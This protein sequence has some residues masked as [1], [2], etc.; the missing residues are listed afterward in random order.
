MSSISTYTLLCI[1]QEATGNEGD[2]AHLA[3]DLIWAPQLYISI[4]DY[5]GEGGPTQLYIDSDLSNPVF[6]QK[7]ADC[8]SPPDIREV[9]GKVV[10][11]QTLAE[12]PRDFKLAVYAFSAKQALKK[13]DKAKKMGLAPAWL[14]RTV[15]PLNTDYIPVTNTTYWG[16]I[17]GQWSILTKTPHNSPCPLFIYIE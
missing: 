7:S 10:V 16:N 13:L 2:L 6:Y 14:T 3:R 4:F 8:V 15:Q 12:K 17:K 5:L 9:N 11:L 1:E